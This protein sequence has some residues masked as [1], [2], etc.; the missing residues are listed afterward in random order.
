MVRVAPSSF[1][2]MQHETH[3]TSP[4][5]GRTRLILTAIMATGQRR[6][7]NARVIAYL[8]CHFEDHS[9][10][11]ALSFIRE[12]RLQHALSGKLNDIPEVSESEWGIIAHGK[13][14]GSDAKSA[15]RVVED[16]R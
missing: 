4:F 1:P 2:D 12:L 15:F 11:G 16:Q 10:R 7:L 13:T 3:A 9:L 6:R 5:W 14:C 8:T